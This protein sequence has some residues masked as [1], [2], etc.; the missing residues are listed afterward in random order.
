MERR[1]FLKKT[2]GLAAVGAASSLLG[3]S[4][5]AS[6]LAQD[7][8][9]S[10][11]KT[12]AEMISEGVV[13]M[14]VPYERTTY[15]A[16]G[17]QILGNSPFIAEYLGRFLSEKYRKNIRVAM[18]PTVPGQLVNAIDDGEADFGSGYIDEYANNLASSRYIVYPH[19]F[20]ESHVLVSRLSEPPVDN[21][22]VL[23]GNIV[24]LGRQTK[25]PVFDHLNAS[26]A[27]SGKK[28]VD[29]YKER[30]VLTDEDMLQ[31]LNDGLL[32]YVYVSQWKANLWQPLLKNIRINSETASVGNTSGGFFVASNNKELSDDIVAFIASPLH[33]VTLNAWR[34]S[35]FQYRVHSLKNPMAALEWKRYLS[36][37]PY[38]ERYGEESHIDPLFVASIGFQESMLNQN[39]VSRSGAVG[40]MQLLP[41]TGASM[42]VG[43]IYTTEANIHAGAKYM[44]VLLNAM[45]LE[46]DLTRVER[47][48]FATAAYNAGAGTIHTA[49]IQAEKMGFNPN[50]WFLNVEM[51]L[52]KMM[53]SQTF[54]YVRDAYKYFVTYDVRERNKRL[55]TDQLII[56]TG[57]AG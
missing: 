1:E 56:N 23:S 18:V 52:A 35:D 21:L 54:F 4:A 6:V 16:I 37:K 19:P 33:D 2:A 5:V 48:L 41:A 8:G 3:E 11:P 27:K 57:P 20:Q 24:C 22:T 26:L 7:K 30:L 13:R 53:G 51:A 55:T 42:R 44:N 45:T 43:N 14:A 46:A 47:A 10:A 25:T 15:V 32:P 12:Y 40:V 34:N 39:L 9:G 49:R 38:F 36:M 17:H 28:P 50:K 31:M 29:V